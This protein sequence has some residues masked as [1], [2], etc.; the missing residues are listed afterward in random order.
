MFISKNQISKW[1]NKA[2]KVSTARRRNG[3]EATLMPHEYISGDAIYFCL[4]GLEYK[5][6]RRRTYM[7]CS[8]IKKK[9]FYIVWFM[10][11]SIFNKI[12]H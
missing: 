1:F 7:T 2:A 9:T 12:C 11:L 3:A 4:K 8:I 10:T 5:H 6:P